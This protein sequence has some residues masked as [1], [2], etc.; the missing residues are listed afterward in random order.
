LTSKM[1]PKNKILF[2]SLGCDKNLVDTEH[3]LGSL[4]PSRYEITNDEEQADIIVIN[5]CCF[6]KDALEESIQTILSFEELRTEGSVKAL[7]VTG[8]LAEQYKK[9]I[10]DELSFVDAVIGTNSYDE[11]PAVIESI[12][13][14][15]DRPVVIKE[16][17][18]LPVNAQ[19]VCTSGGHY[20]YL[21][22]AEGCDKRCTYCIIPYLRGRY[23]SVPMPEL[24]E[25]ARDLA[26][27]GV[28][29]LNI[30]AQDITLY[31]T[32]LYG[33]KR[34]HEL[35]AELAR[36]DGLEWIRLLYC[37]PEDIYDE[38][39]EVI[40]NEPKICHYIDMPIQHCN[41]GILKKMG[42][43]TTKNDIMEKVRCLREEIPDIILRTTLITGFPGESAAD[44][45]ELCEFVREMRFD[46]LGVFTYSAIEGTPA[47]EMPDQIDEDMKE[48]RQAEL[49][50]IQQE[51][52]AEKNAS[53]EGKELTAF[54]EGYMPDDGVY[55]ARTYA[56]APDVDGYL[57]LSSSRNHESGDFV[58]CTVTGGFEYDL[59]GEEL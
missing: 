16:Q 44:H 2:V 17:Q 21:K 18:G 12:F 34:L 40:K 58:K 50:L 10:L 27:Y 25:E 39:I 41:D 28:K 55:A 36:I 59:T 37:Y 42:R 20:S 22:I 4:N 29:E 11:L 14:E 6:I 38:L 5:T 23:R 35:L 19:R 46:R 9:D 54:I 33:E 47:Y 1:N 15:N 49:M 45:E 8:C 57:F 32:D 30:V 53:F 13:A 48:E 56:H 52:S 26:A 3:M 7:I 31:G 51:I 43:R 24:L